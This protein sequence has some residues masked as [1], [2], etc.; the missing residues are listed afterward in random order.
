[1]PARVVADVKIPKIPLLRRGGARPA[2]IQEH[3]R[4]ITRALERGAS[5]ARQVTPVGA[6]A[7]L[8]GTIITQ[9]LIGQQADVVGQ[10]IWA[11]PYAKFVDEGT[12]P[13]IPPIGPLLLWAKRVLG[14]ERAAYA[15]REKIKAEGTEPHNFVEATRQLVAPEVILLYRDAARRYARRL[16]VRG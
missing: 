4:F 12:A 14:N 8:K 6:T 1:M 2:L 10:V 5:L 16:G 15:V 9:K 11:Q 7:L 13:H 3:A